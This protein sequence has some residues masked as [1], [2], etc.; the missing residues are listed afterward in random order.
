MISCTPNIQKNKK[1]C[2][3][4]DCDTMKSH[5]EYK[6]NENTKLITD[7]GDMERLFFVS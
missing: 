3:I 4:S 6:S 1:S 5:A 7:L 2:G